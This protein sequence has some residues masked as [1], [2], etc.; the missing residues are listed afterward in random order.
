MVESG[1]DTQ[2]AN[3]FGNMASSLCYKCSEYCKVS[4]VDQLTVRAPEGME[5]L[6]NLHMLEMVNVG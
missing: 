2:K 3:F 5:K 1:M 6:R 4:G